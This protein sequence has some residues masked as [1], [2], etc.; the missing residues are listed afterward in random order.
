MSEDD[1]V[2]MLLLLDMIEAFDRVIPVQLLLNIEEEK[3]LSEL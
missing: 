3:F 1:G 2:A